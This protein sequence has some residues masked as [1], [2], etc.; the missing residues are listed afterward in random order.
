MSQASAEGGFHQTSTSPRMPRP[1]AAPRWIF[2]STGATGRFACLR[3]AQA[4]AALIWKRAAV[5]RRSSLCT[6]G[7]FIEVPEH[8]EDGGAAFGT[9]R[10]YCCLVFA[11]LYF[12]SA[13]FSL[14]LSLLFSSLSFC[15][16]VYQ[17]S[18]T[19]VLRLFVCLSD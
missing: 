14:S 10:S 2:A 3:R 8:F 7:S 1:A 18:R 11:E 16:S 5:C 12:A 13:L 15:L 17:P 6:V 4:S 19:N 9:I